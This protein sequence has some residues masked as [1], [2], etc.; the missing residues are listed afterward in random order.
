MKKSGRKNNT[1]R[2]LMVYFTNIDIGKKTDWA[3][4]VP[5]WLTSTSGFCPFTD[6]T[7][8]F[9]PSLSKW[10]YCHWLWFGHN[11]LLYL[12]SFFHLDRQGDYL[13]ASQEVLFNVKVTKHWSP[14]T[15]HVK[16]PLFLS[17]V[18]VSS[19]WFVDIYAT[20]GTYSHI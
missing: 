6:H 12:L 20:L 7:D 16:R 11:D 4:L 13:F 9:T 5:G 2:D 3:W 17:F 10:N 8:I 19:I 1:K 18:S 15:I 14:A